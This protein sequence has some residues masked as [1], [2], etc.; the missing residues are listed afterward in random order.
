MRLRRPSRTVTHPNSWHAPGSVFCSATALS[1]RVRDF[2]YTVL[3][4]GQP[5]PGR[6]PDVRSALVIGKGHPADAKALGWVFAGRASA[7]G[8]A[9]LRN[10]LRRLAAD[11]RAPL[12]GVHPIEARP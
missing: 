5:V 4:V 8:G 1:E 11:S 10:R 9:R 12:S 6:R 2:V 7:P 3:V